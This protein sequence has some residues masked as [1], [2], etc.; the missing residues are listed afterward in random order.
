M[1]NV[2]LT[3]PQK[4]DPKIPNDFNGEYMKDVADEFEPTVNR[5]SMLLEPLRTRSVQPV[6]T[7]SPIKQV[8]RFRPKERNL[9]FSSSMDRIPPM[10]TERASPTIQSARS[11][12]IKYK[13]ILK[14]AEKSRKFPKSARE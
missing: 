12:A 13:G 1:A 9:S 11:S 5:L 7:N 3:Q 14:L 8:P 6:K 4:I 10:F 2:K